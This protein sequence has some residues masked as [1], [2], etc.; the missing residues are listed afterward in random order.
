MEKQPYESDKSFTKEEVDNLPTKV[1]VAR[2]KS[3]GVE[4]GKGVMLYTYEDQLWPEHW[5]TYIPEFTEGDQ[6]QMQA[7]YQ[8]TIC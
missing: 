3:V 4:I 2:A 5:F 8:V 7:L 1:S 6:G